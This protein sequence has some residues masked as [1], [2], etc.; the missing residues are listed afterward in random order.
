MSAKV[1]R[2]V[3]LT[4]ALLETRLP[5][6]LESLRQRTGFYTDGDVQSAR[7]MF[8]R[9]KDDLRRLGVPVELRPIPFS[10]EH[11]YI[12]PRDAYELPDVDLDAEEITAL[13]LA[14][15]MTA[16]SQE[17][18]AFAKLAAR[19]PDPV[20]V[21]AD[22]STRVATSVEPVDAVADAVVH[23]TPVSF[24]Y[25]TAAGVRG[26]RRLDPYGVAQRRGVWYLIGRDHDRDA[27]RAFRFDR[28]TSPPE[29][30]GEPA[31]FDVP[32]DVDVTA[33]I[34]GPDVGT[35]DIRVAVAPQAAWELSVRGAARTERVHRGWPVYILRGAHPLRDRS[36][37]L[38]FGADVEVLEP[39]EMRGEVIEALRAVRRTH[40]ATHNRTVEH[41]T[42][43]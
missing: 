26:Q 29:R 30:V 31:S 24:G 35:V 36:W 39:A 19:A 8:E 41:R 18:L 42:T 37:L 23:R 43:P 28:M 9:D 40:R 3:N 32:D 4:I 25:R 38:G 15:R 17:P 12:V 14:L 5:L 6:S 13:A 21:D 7:R 1:E 34:S 16:E 22:P 11:G 27:V 2:L 10:E 20:P 33:A